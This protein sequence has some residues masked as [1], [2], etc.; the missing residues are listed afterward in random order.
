M[1]PGKEDVSRSILGRKALYVGPPEKQ[2]KD[3]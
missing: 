1:M 3:E 2:D